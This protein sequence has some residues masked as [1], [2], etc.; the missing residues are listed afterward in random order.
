MSLDMEG[1]K[2]LDHWMQEREHVRFAKEVYNQPKPWTDDPIIQRYRF[3][4]VRREHDKVTRWFASENGWR[5]EKYWDHPNFIAAIM[6]GRT[7]NWPYTLRRLGFPHIWNSEEYLAAMDRMQAEGD[8]VYTGAYMITAG[9]TGTR[10]N[11]W[12]LGNAETYF[13]SPP[14]MAST[15][16]ETWKNIQAYPCVG[17]FIAGQIV[18]DLKYTKHLKD[19]SDWR[20]WAPLGPGST[21]GLNRLYQRPITASIPQDQGVEEMNEVRAKSDMAQ[22]MFLHDLHDVQNCL[23][24]YDKYERVRLGQGK[25][26][27]SYPGV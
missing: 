3:C 8:K 4:N 20:S 9:P 1:M 27:S 2:R 12:V 14:E 11:L 23:C 13:Q 17:P 21:R 24:E 16:Q 5:N 15:L 10:K 18:A 26:R 19:A 7:I 22:R 25:P 6:L